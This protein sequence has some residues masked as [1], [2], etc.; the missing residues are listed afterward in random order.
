MTK[1]E[2]LEE[3]ADVPDDAVVCHNFEFSGGLGEITSIEFLPEAT[4]MD[5]NEEVKTGPVIEI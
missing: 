3:L 5:G 2:L 1:K 4:Y